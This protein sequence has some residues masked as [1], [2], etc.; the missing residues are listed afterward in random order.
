[1]NETKT[2]T[3]NYGDLKMTKKEKD[4]WDTFNSNKKKPYEDNEIEFILMYPPTYVNCKIIG[5]ILRRS[6]GAIKTI[7]QIAGS[8]IKKNTNPYK[9][10]NKFVKQVQRLKKKMRW[11]SGNN[12]QKYPDKK[13]A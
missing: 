1:V 13:I 3:L 12:L 11:I 9:N 5:R 7:F 4:N 10:N 8:S 6:S 2:V